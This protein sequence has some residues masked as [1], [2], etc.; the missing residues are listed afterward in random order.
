MQNEQLTVDP[1]AS[2]VE[3]TKYVSIQ[4]KIPTFL[5]SQFPD[6]QTSI[7]GPQRTECTIVVT[8]P[9]GPE[10][11]GKSGFW[12]SIRSVYLKRIANCQHFSNINYFV[13]LYT[14]PVLCQGGS[15]KQGWGSSEVFWDPWR[16]PG[17]EGIKIL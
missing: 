12:G 9:D 11:Q 6:D 3:S 8:P 1:G 14:I 16:T 13:I 4:K 17:Q 15:E 7:N 10:S 2:H 5:L